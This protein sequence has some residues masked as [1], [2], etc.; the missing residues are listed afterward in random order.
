MRSLALF[1]L[2]LLLAACRPN[3]DPTPQELQ[4]RLC[5]AWLDPVTGWTYTLGADGRYTARGPLLADG[6]TRLEGEYRCDDEGYV[7]MSLAQRVPRQGHEFYERQNTWLLEELDDERAML[8]VG[9]L[10]VRLLR[11]APCDAVAP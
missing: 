1:L 9:R 7:E 5:G 6:I 11:R 3:P 8:T 4:A 10:R 2:A